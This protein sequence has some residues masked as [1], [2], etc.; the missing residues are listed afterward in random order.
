MCK[1][2]HIC[3]L[4]TLIYGSRHHTAMVI[5]KESARERIFSTEGGRY[6]KPFYSTLYRRNTD[7]RDLLPVF[8][9]PYVIH[10]GEAQEYIRTMGE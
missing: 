2:I 5:L 8:P 3:I 7:R 10:A 9:H 1:N 6:E 4:L